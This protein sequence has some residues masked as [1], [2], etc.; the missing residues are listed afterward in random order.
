MSI[1]IF[2]GT[3]HCGKTNI[4]TEFCKRNPDYQYFKVKQE[5]SF[6]EK[7]DPAILKQ[8]HLMELN[9]FFEL[10]RQVRFNVAMDRF[11][12]SEFV[13]GALFRD[14]DEEKILEFDKLFSELDVVIVLLQKE[15]DKLEDVL[16]TNEQLIEIKKRYTH[17]FEK[18]ACRTM[19]LD[20]DSEDLDWEISEI[21]NFIK[22]YDRKRYVS[23]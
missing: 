15:D 7:V 3:D 6:I 5:Q 9:F 12:P 11:Y 17:F 21:E 8:S 22:S 19:L 1:I 23:K 4:A 18:S 16:W 20:T 13:Y 10:A 2:E 14:I